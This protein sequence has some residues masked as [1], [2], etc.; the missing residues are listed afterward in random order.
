MLR[1]YEGL[2]HETSIQL[3]ISKL[4]NN[5]NELWVAVLVALRASKVFTRGLKDGIKAL[6]CAEMVDG[7]ATFN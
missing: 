5:F 4:C 6:I 7:V 2:F 3:R 1:A